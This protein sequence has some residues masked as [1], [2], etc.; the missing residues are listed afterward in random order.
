MRFSLANIHVQV[1]RR[2]PVDPSH[3]PVLQTE[4]LAAAAPSAR[5]FDDRSDYKG[6]WSALWTN[7]HDAAMWVAGYVDEDELAVSAGKTVNLLMSALDIQTTDRV[8]E[9]GCGIGRV[10]KALA[11]LC[12]TWIGADISAGMIAAARHR[13][14]DQLNVEFVELATVGL[15][16]IEDASVDVVY[17]TVVFM[18]RIRWMHGQRRSEWS[19]RAMNCCPTASGLAFTTSRF[20]DGIT[21]G[22]DLLVPNRK[23]GAIRRPVFERAFSGLGLRIMSLSSP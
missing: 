5:L 12:D 14:A 21:P 7:E 9:I 13:L 1:S 2:P 6:T 23:W 17:C 22:L 19:R 15:A 8:L 11:P 20:G 4:T 3:V 16:E 18:R 10:G